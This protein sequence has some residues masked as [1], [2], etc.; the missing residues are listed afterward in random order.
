MKKIYVSHSWITTKPTEEEIDRVRKWR[1]RTKLCAKACVGITSEALKAGILTDSL[2]IHLN[3]PDSGITFDEDGVAF[4]E[5]VR[6][7]EE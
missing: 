3:T 6:V 7:W 5:G 1:E 4:Y 2:A